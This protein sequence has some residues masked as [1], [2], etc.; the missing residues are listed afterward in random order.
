MQKVFFLFFVVAALFFAC[1]NEVSDS[2]NELKM[3]LMQR[4][5]IADNGDEIGLEKEYL[6]DAEFIKLGI[7][8]K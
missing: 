1:R 4:I 8:S 6:P 5:A 2:S 7:C 3:T